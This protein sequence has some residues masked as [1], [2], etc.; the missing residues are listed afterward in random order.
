MKE[1]TSF[2]FFIY[3]KRRQYAF[4][5]CNQYFQ[6][7]TIFNIYFRAFIICGQTYTRK[8]DVEVINVLASFGGS[9]HKVN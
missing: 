4:D 3:E 5:E 8:L 1:E 7:T 2:L 9:I 6:Y